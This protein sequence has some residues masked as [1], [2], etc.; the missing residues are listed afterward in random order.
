MAPPN[1]QPGSNVN[2]ETDIL[3]GLECTLLTLSLTYNPLSL[4][5]LKSSTM[6]TLWTSLLLLHKCYAL[7]HNMSKM[8]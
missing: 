8:H 6:F 1:A 7:A 3:F 2:E 5:L 4:L